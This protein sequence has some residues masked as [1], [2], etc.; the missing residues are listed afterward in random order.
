M[1]SPRTTGLLA[2]SALI[3]PSLPLRRPSGC[4]PVVPT[5]LDGDGSRQTASTLPPGRAPKRTRTN[6]QDE[7][8]DHSAGAAPN[9]RPMTEPGRR[10]LGHTR[11][12][13]ATST[14]RAM[15]LV[16]P[17]SAGPISQGADTL[18][19]RAVIE[20]RAWSTAVLT[21]PAAHRW[22]AAL[23]RR[24]CRKPD[25]TPT[26][27]PTPTTSDP[28]MTTQWGHACH[29]GN[30]LQLMRAS[31]RSPSYKISRPC[32]RSASGSS[33]STSTYPPCRPAL[34]P[35][36]S[37]ENLKGAFGTVSR[38]PAS[39]TKPSGTSPAT[40]RVT[41]ARRGDV[42]RQSTGRFWLSER[43]RGSVPAG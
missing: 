39:S 26:P 40:M 29:G 13:D 24:R 38:G 10:I 3:A 14:C 42:T 35:S 43:I 41:R 16:T 19:T 9:S 36:V 7:P 33:S 5:R 15:A 12:V 2:S 21:V 6:S 23:N 11:P 30:R 31:R 25:T 22:V 20:A 37:T 8:T 32:C 18:V 27:L 28:A 4:A 17:D 34:L 1:R